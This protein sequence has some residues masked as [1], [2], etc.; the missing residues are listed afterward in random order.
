MNPSKSVTIA[1]VLIMS[2][3]AG[4]NASDS[5]KSLFSQ[6]T[7]GISDAISKLYSESS[8]FRNLLSDNQNCPD[9]LFT[10][11]LSDLPNKYPYESHNVHTQ[12][13]Y[14]LKVFRIQ[15][16]N[17]KIVSGKKV[18]FM[19]HGLID[20]SDDWIINEEEYSLGL[21]LANEGYDV[22]LGNSRGNKYSQSSYKKMSNKEYWSFSLQE[23]G[24]YDV[25]AN[26]KYVL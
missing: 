20:S 12:D 10:S 25:P 7:D 13:G 17:T 6:K 8:S 21:V 15:A 26:I 11:I 2:I 16:K 18:V 23:M 9:S 19:Q 5:M 1:I 14:I 4:A 22:W 3:V 24:Q